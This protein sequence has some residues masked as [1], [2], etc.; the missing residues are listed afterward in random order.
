ALL[1]A[2]SDRGAGPRRDGGGGQQPRRGGH[3]L[4]AD[5]GLAG[6]GQRIRAGGLSPPRPA[7]CAFPPRRDMI[8]ALEDRMRQDMRSATLTVLALAMV[9]SIASAPGVAAQAPAAPNTSASPSA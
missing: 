1:H 6:R 9:A 7:P 2:R 4:P 8:Q 3:D 5:R